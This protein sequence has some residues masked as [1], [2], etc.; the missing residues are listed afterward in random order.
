MMSNIFGRNNGVNGF[1]ANNSSSISTSEAY[2]VKKG[3]LPGHT[4]AN[5]NIFGQGTIS[6]QQ[7]TNNSAQ[8][9][10]AQIFN[11]NITQNTATNTNT[12]THQNIF[13]QI[14]ATNK[15][16][17][18]FQANPST[19]GI[20]QRNDQSQFTSPFSNSQKSNPLQSQQ[21]NGIFKIQGSQAGSQG[22]T[23]FA[24]LFNQGSNQQPQNRHS[25]FFNNQQSSAGGIFP[26]T[27]TYNSNTSTT[28]IFPK[29]TQPS[30]QTFP[31]QQQHQAFTPQPNQPF[32]SQQNQS[33]QPQFLQQQQPNANQMFPFLQQGQNQQQNTIFGQPRQ[34]ISQS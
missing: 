10:F 13:S 4:N 6:G 18:P 26:N 28:G 9:P 11:K 8:T 31:F 32:Q 15:N 3:Q 29:S 2:L 16:V 7:G 17:S 1:S 23:S 19:T 21:G 24:N 27:Q 33:L 5:T 30:Q 25:N 12:S 22:G 20:F 14:N 34:Q